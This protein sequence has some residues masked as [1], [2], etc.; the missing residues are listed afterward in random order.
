MQFNTVAT[1]GQSQHEI[2]AFAK[3]APWSWFCS[4]VSTGI[5]V[6]MWNKKL[7]QAPDACEYA[8]V[9]S[10]DD[11]HMYHILHG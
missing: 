11:N 8:N 4:I 9:I 7:A 1:A 5:F 10:V 6:W 3:V 2:N